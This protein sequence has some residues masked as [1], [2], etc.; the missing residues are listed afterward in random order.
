MISCQLCT[1]LLDKV[2]MMLIVADFANRCIALT[3]RAVHCKDETCI[4][5]LALEFK[6]SSHIDNLN[7][8]TVASS[9]M[10]AMQ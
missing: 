9:V 10:C 8:C 3:V 4:E 7:R 5:R 6:I 2:L 1:M